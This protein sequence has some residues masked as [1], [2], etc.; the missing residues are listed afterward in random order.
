MR[1]GLDARFLGPESK[2]LG[3]HSY[4]LIRELE[5]IDTENEYIV[6]LR[7]FN[8]DQFIPRN[9]NFHRALADIP[10]YSVEEQIRFPRILNTYNLD[11]MHFLHFNVPI[12]YKRPFVVTIHD[13]IL[14]D[15]PTRKNSTRSALTYRLKHEG[16]KRVIRHAVTR[17][18]HII[19]TSQFTKDTI[20]F[21]FPVPK[22]KMTPIYGGV[23]T[24]SFGISEQSTQGGDPTID[25][26]L[27]P[28]RYVLYV[29]NAYPHKNLEGLLRVFARLIR[30]TAYQHWKLV[31]VGKED[32]FYRRIQA[33]IQDLGISDSVVLTGFVSD[34]ALTELYRQAG[35]FVFPSLYEGFGFPPLEALSAGTPALVSNYTSL[36]E[37]C[38]DVVEYFDPQNTEV[39]L[40]KLM[41]V[42]DN[43]DDIRQTQQRASPDL[44]NQYSWRTMAQQTLNVYNTL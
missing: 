43:L 35:L 38:G 22:Q 15:Y 9:A 6:F 37:V 29:G 27:V 23:D 4:K 12:L 28:Y 16:Y 39:W 30:N 26:S 40:Q 19:T 24:Q 13:L 10:W 33:L 21:H 7:K 3:R 20:H 44:L 41:Y 17:S 18:E 31:L 14:L 11:V 32:Y 1:I 2:G 42:L 36:P 5:T 34:T 25:F 8:Y